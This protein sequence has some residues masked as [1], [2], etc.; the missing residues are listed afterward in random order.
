MYTCTSFIISKLLNTTLWYVREHQESFYISDMKHI[1][2][3]LQWCNDLIIISLNF[4]C[5]HLKRVIFSSVV[6][7]KSHTP[8]PTVHVLTWIQTEVMMLSVSLNSANSYSK[9]VILQV[10]CLASLVVLKHTV[11][12]K[13]LTSKSSGIP[14]I[15][16]STSSIIRH[17]VLIG[18]DFFMMVVV[19]DLVHY[20]NSDTPT[21]RPIQGSIKRTLQDGDG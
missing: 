4:A 6:F 3:K 11:L 7:W 15:S 21:E 9:R 18:D 14:C 13:P 2:K 10:V 17:S 20:L 8:K 16:N 12:K 19:T 1:N 5:P